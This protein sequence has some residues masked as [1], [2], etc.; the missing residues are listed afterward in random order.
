MFSF[1]KLLKSFAVLCRG[2]EVAHYARENFV[3]PNL[4]DH[5]LHSWLVKLH[6]VLHVECYNFFLLN[7]ETQ[8]SEGALKPVNAAFFK[9]ISDYEL[10]V[11]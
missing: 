9:H 3:G 4:R 5:L 1:A 2:K 7:V 11:H 6:C 8:L 10:S